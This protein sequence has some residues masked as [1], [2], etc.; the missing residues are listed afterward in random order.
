MRHPTCYSMSIPARKPS[1]KLWTSIPV[2]KPLE[3]P[4]TN[5]SDERSDGPFNEH[6][7]AQTVVKAVVEHCGE[8]TVGIAVDERKRSG[9]RRTIRCQFRHANRLQSHQ[10][11]LQRANC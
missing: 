11:V 7:G 4:L 8:Q 10:Q 6:Y 5:G 1:S 3:E 9:I 2:H